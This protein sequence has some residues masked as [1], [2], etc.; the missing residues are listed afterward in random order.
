MITTQEMRIGNC[1][2]VMRSMEAES[3]TAVVTDPPYALEF[4]GKDWDM[5]IP[6]SVY[7]REALRVAKPGAMLLAFGG[8]RTHHRLMVAIEDAGW[9]IRDTLCWM[10]GSGFPKSHDIGKG[11][12]RTTAPATD[13]AKIWDGYGTALKPAWE[14][15]ILAMK[16]IDG[17]FAQN[18]LKHGVV[19]INVD[20]TRIPHDD[21]VDLAAVQN[22]KTEQS[23]DTVTLN[24][25]GFSTATY[26]SNS[27]WPANVVLDEEAGALLDEQS[28]PKMHGAGYSKE[29]DVPRGAGVSTNFFMG[30]QGVSTSGGRFGDTGGASRFFYCAKASNEDRGGISNVHPTV[31]PVSL[32]RWLV[33]MVKMPAGTVVLDP[34]AGSGSTGVACKLEDVDFIG[35]ERESYYARTAETRINGC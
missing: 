20:G 22:C 17:T 16:P 2:D 3:V 6:G 24:V 9:V 1:Y 12:D 23:G 21:G 34:F 7:W 5:C 28:A 33:R 14:P 15:I 4:M 19:G 32:M 11:I 31:K 27:R 10:Y 30:P 18:A 8:T 35:I 26:K 29:N 13:A 25:P